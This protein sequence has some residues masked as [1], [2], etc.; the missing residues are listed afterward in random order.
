MSVHLNQ[1]NE[2]LAMSKQ[3]IEAHD[4]FLVVSHIQPDGDAASSTC[5]VGWL[6]HQLNKKYTMV[7][8]G[9][10]PDKFKYLWGY[11]TISD[12]SSI[13][14]NKKFKYIITVDCADYSRI[15]RVNELFAED[16]IILNIDHHPTN[17]RYGAINFIDNDAAATVV[18]LYD[19][20]E[21]MKISWSLDIA[22]CIYTGLLTDTGGFRYANTSTKVMRIASALITHGVN[23]NHMAEELLEKLT[24]PHIYLLKKA[25][26]SLSFSGNKQISWVHLSLEDMK[27]SN[28][29]S[30]DVEGIVNY[31]RNIEGVEVGIFFKEIEDNK[32]KVSFRSSGK[33]DV[34]QLAQVF[35][36]GGHVLASGATMEGSIEEVT[37]IIL[38]AIEKELL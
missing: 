7:N 9:K 27:S 20:L 19:L 1:Y 12:F 6:L 17:D 33:V 10:I 35:G 31:P 15:G 8:E 32:V 16:A 5:A 21:N 4:D 26:N 18:L 2:Q 30:E 13:D 23:A 28:A 29:S 3:F 38:N 36:G 25:L 37:P 24:V 34:A 22:N 11:S 14:I